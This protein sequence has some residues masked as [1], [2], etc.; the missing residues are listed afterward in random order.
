VRDECLNIN[1]CWSLIQARVIIGD[2]EHD[3]NHYRRHSS[4]GCL[5][6]ARYAA[7]CTHR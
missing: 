6:P 5:P 7:G 1:T 3:Y 2:W 4:L